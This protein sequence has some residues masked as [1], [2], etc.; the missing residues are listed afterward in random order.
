[1]ATDPHAVPD[2]KEELERKTL[3]ELEN[4]V[5][6]LDLGKITNAEYLASINTLFAVCSGLVDGDF[7]Q[8]ISAASKEAVKDYS[9]NRTRIFRKEDKVTI[10]SRK[11]NTRDFLVFALNC[12]I[13]G[14]KRIK[15][16]L[17]ETD[18]N[19]ETEQKL[20]AIIDKLKA[21]GFKEIS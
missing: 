6:A 11:K 10:I 18:T 14:E 21:A 13:T 9:F 4:L 15:G 20:V 16:Q 2:I 19:A 1:M 7:F 12:A 3:I 8:L 17:D 5:N